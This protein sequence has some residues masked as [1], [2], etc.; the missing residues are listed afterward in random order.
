M[1]RHE[2]IKL[3]IVMNLILLIYQIQRKKIDL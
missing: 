1:M 3:E 2:M